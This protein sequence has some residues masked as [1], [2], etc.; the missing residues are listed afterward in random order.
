MT[1]VDRLRRF[2]MSF[3]LLDDVELATLEEATKKD[4]ENVDKIA[5]LEQTTFQKV[6]L[7]LNLVTLLTTLLPSLFVTFLRMLYRMHLSSKRK[8]RRFGRY[9]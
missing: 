2:F 6:V 4:A 1:V 7:H 3:V 5:N 9:F 8:Q